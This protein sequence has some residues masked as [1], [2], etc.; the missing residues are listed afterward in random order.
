MK[1]EPWRCKTSFTLCVLVACLAIG[2][3]ADEWIDPD[4]DCTWTYQLHDDD[5]VEILGA[6]PP[7]VGVVSIP[8][9]VNGKSVARIGD[10]AF[11]SCRGM[12]GV[13]IPDGVKRI[14]AEAFAN[15]GYAY[16]EYEGLRMV[17]IPN[18]VV[19]I[20]GGAFR[21]CKLESVNIPGRVTS[22]ENGTFTGC[23]ELKSVTIPH[24]VT[25]IGDFAFDNCSS[26]RSIAI[27][28]SVMN[29]GDYAFCGCRNLKSV[30]IPG[31]VVAIGICA[32]NDCGV[33][34]V[35][36]SDGVVRI[37]D[38][39]FG[40][41]GSL[42]KLV[43]P[44]SVTILG[45]N[46]FSDCTGLASVIM[47][48]SCVAQSEDGYWYGNGPYEYGSPFSGCNYIQNVT[49]PRTI[50]GFPLSYLFP[51]SGGIT[52]VVVLDGT[53]RIRDEA[54]SGFGNLQ[55]VKFPPSVMQVGNR[56]FS[57]CSSL[58]SVVFEGS[59]PEVG[60]NIYSGTSTSLITYVNSGSI[61]WAGGIS[62][63]LP[64]TWNDRAIAYIGTSVG[65]NGNE[66]GNS[67]SN[68]F[69]SICTTN[70]VVHYVRNSVVPEFATPVSTDV[71]FVTV[72]TEIRGGAVAIPESWAAN[73]PR[74]TEM[75]G[76]DFSS[77]LTK[78]TGKRDS[79]GNA[80]LVWHDYVAG[81]DPTKEDDVF[82]ASITMVDGR[83]VVSYAPELPEIEKSKRKYTIYG[84]TRLQDEEWQVADDNASK[85]NFFKVTVEMK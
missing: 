26:L 27:P 70:I 8:A 85:Y 4:T 21:F 20:G 40:H 30:T 71:G 74:F 44:N 35:V 78:S 62:T 53:T 58:T 28:N 52:N 2:V 32:F 19:E 31:S 72:I 65:I 84:K 66:G 50:E 76:A 49:V 5:T 15:P 16:E 45:R 63:E 46:A 25:R 38:G 69:V 11:A 64:Q 43:L 83:P 47:L 73:Y 80:L 37:G 82:M 23:S 41:C 29:I 9:T 22:I 36:I 18:S 14:G 57:G 39:A 33:E 7:L 34:N 61:G 12:T 56:A 60:E 6:S 1:T 24:S 13:I 10:W 55:S 81:T 67:S 79:Q 48:N 54:F 75:F 51:D 59:A 42:T 17:Q 3:R 77:A 68:T